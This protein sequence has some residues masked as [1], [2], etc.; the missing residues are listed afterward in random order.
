MHRFRPSAAGQKFLQ[1]LPVGQVQ[2]LV[3]GLDPALFVELTQHPAHRHP[4]H[5]HRGADL[6]VGAVEQSLLVGG[7][8]EQV[9]DDALYIDADMFRELGGKYLFSRIEIGNAP[10]LGFTLIGTYSGEG[11][12]YTIY[13][14]GQE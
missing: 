3:A 10:E 14:Y 9:A 5:P 1:A 13:V 8:R 2:A 7:E 11:S 6:L 4:A 12:P